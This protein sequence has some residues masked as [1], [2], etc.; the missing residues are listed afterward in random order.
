M[1]ATTS[2][3]RWSLRAAAGPLATAAAVGATALALHLRDPHQQGSWGVCPLYAVTGLYCPGCGGLRAINDITNGSFGAALG[4][5][6]LVY[7]AAAIV[8]WLWIGWLGRKV[9]FRVPS[10]P[11]NTY[12]WV[13]VGVL[14]AVWTV[15]RNLPGSPLAP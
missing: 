11:T 10:L 7:P 9:G 2:P 12:L 5:N 13:T 3:A 4:S 8:V 14:I 15:A 1:T 6:A